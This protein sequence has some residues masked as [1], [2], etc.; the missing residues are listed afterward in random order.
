[1]TDANR[2]LGKPSG[3]EALTKLE[4]IQRTGSCSDGR[5]CLLDFKAIQNRL[6]DRWEAKKHDVYE[7]I[8]KFIQRIG[9]K[10]VIYSVVDAAQFVVCYSEGD[11]PNAAGLSYRIVEEVLSHFL[12]A[13]E[14]ADVKISYVTSV[15][16][17]Q[18]TSRALNAQEAR[19]VQ[20]RSTTALKPRPKV[21]AEP[22]L[23][24]D[25]AHRL[26]VQYGVETVIAVRQSTAMGYRLSVTLF[27]EHGIRPLAPLERTVL[28]TASLLSIDLRTLIE[29]NASELLTHS[30]PC[31][32]V[33]LSVQSFSNSRARTAI[34]D[35]MNRLKVEQRSRLLVE[36]VGIDEGA[37][38]SR[39]V[40]A[41]ALLKPFCRRVVLQTPV[42]RVGITNVWSARPAAISVASLD[43]GSRSSKLASGLLAAGEALKGTAATLIATGLASDTDLAVCEVA[44]FT[45]ATLQT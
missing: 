42:G 27:D 41:A 38:V 28:P 29:A 7:L 36:L 31:V 16:D 40:E 37:P 5:V 21:T 24:E 9:G 1:M 14:P 22:I 34:F 35:V 10:S 44:G 18:V 33:P 8:G 15:V 17:G 4:T 20:A 23:I 39:L 45:H 12:G 2:G 13:Y 26:P 32:M 11:R 3:V 25:S 19:A 30:Y 43:I 6:E